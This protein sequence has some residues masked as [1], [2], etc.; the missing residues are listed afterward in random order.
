MLGNAMPMGRR[1]FV[2]G[3]G[4]GIAGAALAGMAPATGATVADDNALAWTPAWRLREMIVRKKISP[5]EVTQY[6]LG[7]IAALDPVLHAYLAVDTKGALAQARLAEQAVERGPDALGPLHGVPLSIKDLYATKGLTTTQGSQIYRDFVPDFDELLVERLRRA[8][9]IIIG[10]THTPEFATFP[11]T[12]TLLAGECVNPWDLD[13][14]PGASSGGAA[15]AVAAGMS[16]F[17]I[18][19]DG[20]GSTRIP[21]ALC[22]VFGFQPSSGRIPMRTPT[23]VHMASAGPITLDVR[24]AAIMMEAMAGRDARDPSAIDEAAPALV[25]GLDGGIG[26]LR[27]GWSRDWGVIPEVN[28]AVV[29]LAEQAAAM[30]EKAGA[31]VG[32]AGITLPDEKAWGVFIAMNEY[33]YR[34]TGRLLDFTPEQRTLLTPPV[35]RM[36][37]HVESA[38]GRLFAPDQYARYFEDRADL[39]RWIN[40]VFGRFDLICTPTMGNIAPPVPA[41]E[42]DQ[43]YL[44]QYSAEHIST[45]Y[46]YIANVLGLPAATVPCGFVDGMPV[47][48]QIVGPRLAD[49]RVM[50][51]AY[52]FS[53]IRPWA[54]THPDIAM[55]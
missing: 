42:W 8:G 1:N 32:Q 7:R 22:G 51:A 25:E 33:S 36:L 20:G 29:N 41:G 52:A 31:R 23:S 49:E 17:A 27:I 14:I 6:F 34:R 46:T 55:L 26:G 16:A 39:V 15:A 40:E 3:L 45:N 48:L 11:R 50:R 12:K 38:G 18:G 9:A 47:G 37:Q 5:V 44:D 54:D 30:F 19:S 2:A 43:P 13:R 53:R 35:Q 24:D 10:K 4:A 28:K 21:A